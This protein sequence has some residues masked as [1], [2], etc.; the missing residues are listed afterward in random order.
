MYGRNYKW[1]LIIP[2]ILFGLAIFLA[3]GVK[4]GIDLQGGSIIIV[5]GFNGTIDD[6]KAILGAYKGVEIISN[7]ISGPDGKRLMIQLP[8]GESAISKEIVAALLKKG[9]RDLYVREIGA[10]VGELFWRN[11]LQVSLIAAFFITAIIFL[12]FREFVP[13]IAIIVAAIFDIVF[14]LA[15]MALFNV[16]LSLVSISALLMLI[17]YSVDTDILL[18]TKLLK[19]RENPREMAKEA[20][21]TGVLMT[22]T[23]MAAVS[24]ILGFS[25]IYKM[26][27]LFS[28][29]IILFFGLLGDILYT[30]LGNAVI[31][32]WY[33]ESKKIRKQ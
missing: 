27:V 22:L 8:K 20:M 18:T 19:S 9:Y 1:Y 4:R 12:I 5:N 26:E 31:L 32:L 29:S 33:V 30:W 21:K 2:F 6:V 24:V 16:P 17:G 3:S 13:A 23:S 10:T 28:I 25:F 14:A 11:A 7:V 15:A